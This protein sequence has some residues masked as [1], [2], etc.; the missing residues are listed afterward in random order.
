[1]RSQRDSL[2]FV[3][4]VLCSPLPAD[5]PKTR[6]EALARLESF[7][8]ESAPGVDTTTL[9]GKVMTGYQGWFNCPKDGSGR[10]WVHYGR[11]KRFSPKACTIDLWPDVSELTKEERFATEF[12]KKDGSAAE[13]F[14]SHHPKTVDRHF[15]WMKEY[16]IDGAFVQRFA[17]T[18]RSTRGFNHC[19]RVLTSCRAAANRHGRAYAIMYDLSGL[20]AGG[21]QVVIDD[22][23]VLVDRFQFGK[24]GDKAY[25]RHRG[26]LVVAVWGIG[27]SDGR[28]YSL[29]ECERLIRFL[30]D[31]PKYGGN[32]VMLGVPT[33]WR[34][35]TRD[36]VDDEKLHE[37]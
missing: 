34:T 5:P 37:I 10:G 30:K 3:L 6:D 36:A 17:V 32:T 33:Y 35:K 11:G 7:R 13:V 4:A 15:R 29:G 16:G 14:S 19:N 26:K 12:R 23:K 21:T 8:G 24:H 18:T 2:V 20:G 9:N 25:L 22:W 1:M 27:F 31:D 28:K